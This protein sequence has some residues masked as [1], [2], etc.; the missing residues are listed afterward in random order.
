MKENLQETRKIPNWTFL[1]IQINTNCNL[2]CT[3]CSLLQDQA[4]EVMSTERI[5]WIF[6]SPEHFVAVNIIAMEP[7]LIQKQYSKCHIF[8]K[9]AW[10]MEYL[11]LL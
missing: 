9:N 4:V 11:F 2:R 10:S 3:H 7:L 5:D 1:T 6:E 8:K